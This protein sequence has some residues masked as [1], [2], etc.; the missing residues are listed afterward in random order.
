[1]YYSFEWYVEP[2]GK[3]P[4]ND[5]LLYAAGAVAVAVVIIDCYYCRGRKP[6]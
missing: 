3:M 4:L 6:S 2:S 1:M 5:V